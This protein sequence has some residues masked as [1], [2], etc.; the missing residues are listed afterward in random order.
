[1]DKAELEAKA[2]DM[3]SGIAAANARLRQALLSGAA[4][5]EIRRFLAELE[6]ELRVV[7]AEIG[8]VQAEQEAAEARKIEEAGRDLARDAARRLKAK[9]QALQPPPMPTPVEAS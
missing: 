9:L 5:G 1:M 6:A 3:K 4:T 7:E 8:I 2:A